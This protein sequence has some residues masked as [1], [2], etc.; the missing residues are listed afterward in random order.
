[1]S[2]PKPVTPAGLKCLALLA[3]GLTCKEIAARLNLSPKTVN[4]QLTVNY[5]RIGVNKE[6]AAVAWYVRNIE[7]KGIQK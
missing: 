2:H 5:P 7:F 1:M 4:N 6:T 3:E